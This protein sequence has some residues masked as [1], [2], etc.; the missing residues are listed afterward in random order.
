MLKSCFTQYFLSIIIYLEKRT[1]TY[2]NEKI[3]F[4]MKLG[5]VLKKS[6]KPQVEIIVHSITLKT[7]P[8]T[9]IKLKLKKR[10]RP[11]IPKKSHSQ[12]WRGCQSP[13]AHP[14]TDGKNPLYHP[15]LKV[16]YLVL[17]TTSGRELDR[18]LSRQRRVPLCSGG[19][20]LI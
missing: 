2:K 17:N 11:T 3:D 18:V 10:V 15:S 20:I 14:G 12:S 7:Q 6:Y 8:N 1:H 13:H 4:Q 19:N 16:D 9:S 5:S